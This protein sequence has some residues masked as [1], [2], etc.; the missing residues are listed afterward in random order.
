MGLDQWCYAC[1]CEDIPDGQR[2]D[3]S[4]P[5]SSVEIAYWR[6]HPNLHGWMEAL[7]KEKGGTDQQFNCVPVE[8]TMD[9]LDNLE[10]AIKED[11]LPDT[12][13]FFFGQSYKDSHAL[14]YDLDFVK[15]AKQLINEEDKRIFYTSW[16]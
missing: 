1:D 4:R 5:E 13:G 12:V 7:Y 8:L 3:F 10:E 2:V 14:S 15:K 6:K 11:R 9:D 16:W